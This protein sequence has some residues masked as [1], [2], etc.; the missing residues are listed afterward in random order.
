MK[1]LSTSR[2]GNFI[3]EKDSRDILEL[4]YPKWYSSQAYTDYNGNNILIEPKNIW[5]RSFLIFKNDMEIGKISFSWRT[6]IK[7]RLGSGNSRTDKNY[8]LKAR[9]FWNKRFELMNEDDIVLL[10]LHSKMNWK[11][12]KLNYDIEIMNA[13]L[14]EE[15]LIELLIYCGFGANMYRKMQAAAAS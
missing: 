5:R 12:F 8:R 1:I 2:R 7:I 10:T 4:V 13:N 9:G 14:Q 6:N 3:L 15:Q 11:R